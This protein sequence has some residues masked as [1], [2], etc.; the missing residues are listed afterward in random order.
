MATI[1]NN[2]QSTTGSPYAFYTVKAEP[3]S[4]SRTATTV[5]VKVTVTWHLQ[6]AE[7]WWGTGYTMTAGI[8]LGSTWNSITLKASSTVYEGTDTHTAT[9]TFTVS[10]LTETQTSLTGIQF[11]VQTSN[12]TYDGGVLTATS[13]SNLAIDYYTAPE[14]PVAPALADTSNIAVPYIF[15]GGVWVVSESNIT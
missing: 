4:G 6:Y 9:G 5:Q 10:G 15:S 13:C 11:R 3:V 8:Y 1:L 14:Q 12:S 7:S 2:K